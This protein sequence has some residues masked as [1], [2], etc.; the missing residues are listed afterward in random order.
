M[1]VVEKFS[2]FFILRLSHITWQIFHE[3]IEVNGKAK[4]ICKNKKSEFCLI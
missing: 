1:V 3:S 2:G 4:N